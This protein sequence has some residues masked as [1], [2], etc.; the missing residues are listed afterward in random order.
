MSDNN[1]NNATIELL[2]RIALLLGEEL[3]SEVAFMGAMTTS[4]LVHEPLNRLKD[5]HVVTQVL[6]AGDWPVFHKALQQRGFRLY[7]K[8]GLP[9][10]ME[11]DGLVVDFLPN[12]E[13]VAGYVNR[14]YRYA[15]GSAEWFIL[16]NDLKIKLVTPV[17]CMATKLEIWKGKGSNHA[18]ISYD[19]EDIFNLMTGRV[20]LVN[21]I[22]GAEPDVTNFILRGLEALLETDGF[23][24][25]LSFITSGNIQR[26]ALIF[27]F[28]KTMLDDDKQKQDS[29]E[30]TET[31]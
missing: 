6:N 29:Q 22:R 1:N 17:W 2:T 25:A 14:C 21:E 19:M 27:E 16:E 10:R 3:L 31:T 13:S 11:N 26:Q 30:R 9:Y 4:L 15:L 24:D 12:H 20:K 18:M 8:D 7:A 28:L 5:A 23:E